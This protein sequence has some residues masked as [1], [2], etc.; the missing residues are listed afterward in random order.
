MKKQNP[1]RLI[2]IASF[3]CGLFTYIFC[4]IIW[5]AISGVN[6]LGFPVLNLAFIANAF[7]CGNIAAFIKWMF[8]RI[9]VTMV[10]YFGNII[11]MGAFL[12]ISF[13]IAPPDVEAWY[14]L[15]LVG[16]LF[17]S[18]IPVAVTSYIVNKKLDACKMK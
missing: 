6:L 2:F 16:W 10:L 5:V 12:L 1:R 7:I 14:L 4:S 17:I 13:C 18:I 3:L 9:P 8:S 15:F 11:P